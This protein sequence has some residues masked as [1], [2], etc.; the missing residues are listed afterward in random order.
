MILTAPL[1][2]VVMPLYNKRPYVTRAVNS[3]LGQSFPDWELIV[4]DDGSTDGSARDV[5]TDDQRI[6][7]V[8]QANAGPAAARNRGINLARG[9]YVTFLDADDYYYVNKLEQELTLLHEER[10]AEWMISAFDLA[11]DG[12]VQLCHIRDRDGGTINGKPVVFDNALRQLTI[13]FWPVNAVCATSSLLNRIGGFREEMRW[14]EI[15]DMQLRCALAE[16]RVVVCPVPLHRV[17]D[18]PGSAAKISAHRIDAMRQ[19]GAHLYAL[20]RDHPGSADILMPRSRASF[21]SYVTSLICFGARKEARRFLS[22]EFPYG[23]DRKWWKLWVGTWL[24]ARIIRRLVFTNGS[25]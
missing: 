14:L 21:A 12:R 23:R 22:T 6:H 8:S 4:V 13:A 16:P 2:S 3:V 7:L 15:T 25:S 19:M 10:R 1:I 24:P 11:L 20:S 9:R 5:T 18:V 17:V